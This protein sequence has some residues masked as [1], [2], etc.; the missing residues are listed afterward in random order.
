MTASAWTRRDFL[1]RAMATGGLAVGALTGGGVLLGACT[2]IGGGGDSLER[3]RRSGTIKIG[4]ADE[5]PFGFL[6]R[7]GRVSG[8]AP[9]VA[10]VVFAAL[11]INTVQPVQV[12]FTSLIAGLV[13]RRYDVVAA[14]LPITPQRCSQVAFSVPDYRAYT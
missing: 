13:A 5:R 10:R 8:E 11:G 2:S 6:A 7:D 12:G 3:A 1:S 9:E 4:T 14:G